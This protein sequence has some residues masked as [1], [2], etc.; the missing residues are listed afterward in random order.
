MFDWFQAKNTKG[1]SKLA[2]RA[3]K[4][5]VDGF[6]SSEINTFFAISA[7]KTWIPRNSWTPPRPGVGQYTRFI[8]FWSGLQTQIILDTSSQTNYTSID[9]EQPKKGRRRET[10]TG[11]PA[12]SRRNQQIHDGTEPLS[13]GKKEERRRETCT[14]TPP[15]RRGT[16]KSMIKQNPFPEIRKKR[17]ERRQAPEPSRN[18]EKP[19][20][21]DG[22]EAFS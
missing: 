4:R 15:E 1:K 22:I 6:N 10:S 7:K 19:V 11:T 9:P 16:R 3:K 8:Q 5:V 18:Q 12:R 2:R 13:W 14:R 17:E 21:H 20:N